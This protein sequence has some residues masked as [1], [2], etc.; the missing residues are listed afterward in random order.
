M[1]VFEISGL[2]NLCSTYVPRSEYRAS[3]ETF[4][5]ARLL[6][7]TPL[8]LQNAFGAIH[9]S[10]IPDQNQRGRMFERAMGNLTAWWADTFFE[11]V[12]KGHIRNRPYDEIQR[13]LEIRGLHIKDDANSDEIS[14][15]VETLEDIVGDEVEPIR[16][17]KSL[18]KHALMQSGS[19]DT[20]AQLFTALCRGLGIPAR[21]VVSIQSVPW[22]AGIGKPKPQYDRKKLK[23]KGKTKEVMNDEVDGSP[24]VPSI[25]DSNLTNG[26]RLDGGPVPSTSEKAKGKQKAAHVIKLRKTKSKGQV[27]GVAPS[28]LGQLHYF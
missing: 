8:H 13:K 11:V 14:L 17:S 15:D 28:K 27:L 10:R 19:R 5:Q 9:K 2:T 26:R 1:A 21:L 4:F 18:M 20:S 12:P 25:F 7:L 3:H 16:S 22:Q 6:S 23:G 24:P